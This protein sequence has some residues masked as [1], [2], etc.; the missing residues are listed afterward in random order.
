MVPFR[1]VWQ[2]PL[3]GEDF[4]RLRNV[5][6][7]CLAIGAYTAIAVQPV[8][9][10]ESGKS[11]KDATR[12]SVAPSGGIKTPGVQIPF[13]SLKPEAEFAVAANWLIF[14]DAPLVADQKSLYRIDARKNE[15]GAAVA[16]LNTP[17]GGA[18]SA[19][20]SLWI[21]TCGDQSLVRLD[22]KTW[23]TAA[24]I[25][26]GTGTAKP[27]LAATTD[28]IWMFT[29]SK[30]TLSRIDP[31]KNAV[32]AELRLGLGCNNLTFG[33]ASLWVTCPSENRV[34]R[35]NP[36]T[37]LVDK[38]IE[39]SAQPT[40]LAIG[41]SSVWVYC[42]KDGKIDRIDPKTNT[43]TKTIELGVPG[44]E[45]SIA[46]GAGS[47]WVSAAG[48]PL[49]RIDPVTSKVVQQF[50]GPGG[51]AVSFGQNSIWLY[52]LPEGKLW[53]VDPKR[54]AATIAE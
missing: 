34:V 15:L 2:L 53:R 21:P 4:M 40:A 31:E 33:E 44:V 1:P 35:V 14:S 43:V 13:A 28:S 27:A 29:D 24:T 25:A 30:T 36:N 42:Q 41:E 7:L 49:T 18:G 19:F 6:C 52:D 46:I 51:G 32:V 39:V 12:L 17:C 9:K 47:A 22:P 50:W 20:T 26:V 16:A 5:L 37:N 8:G 45:G 23:K 54:V 3:S 38:R 11:K 48:F 10:P